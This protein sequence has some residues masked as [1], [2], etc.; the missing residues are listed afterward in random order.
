M[1]FWKRASK[2]AQLLQGPRNGVLKRFRQWKEYCWKYD[3]T[4]YGTPYEELVKREDGN[5]Q[6]LQWMADDVDVHN[7][8]IRKFHEQIGT[9]EA[10]RISAISLGF[11]LKRH[12]DE[13]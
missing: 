8:A 4:L 11:S 2:F 5:I 6:K 12:N 3:E 13:R 10:T 9:L 1:R 7:E